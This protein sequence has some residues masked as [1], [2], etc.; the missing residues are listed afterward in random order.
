MNGVTFQALRRTCATTLNNLGIDGKL[1]ADQLGHTSTSAKTCT[2]KQASP[3]K[4]QPS[5]NSTQQSR[6]KNGHEH[7]RRSNRR[8]VP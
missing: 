8:A 3:D 2:Q 5:N 6:R 7:L 1:V 4:Q